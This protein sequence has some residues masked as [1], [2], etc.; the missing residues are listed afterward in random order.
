MADL[1]FDYLVLA[2][3]SVADTSELDL[4]R[5][6]VFTLKTLQDSRLIRNHII[7]LFERASVD[8]DPEHQKQLLTFVVCGGGYTGVQLVTEL[9]DFI[10]RSLLRFYKILDTSNIRIMLVEAESKI[11]CRVAYQAWC[12]CDEATSAYGD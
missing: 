3:G 9:R 6:N 11:V 1:E 7:G 10:F 2:L 4:T 12:L 5:E 8:K